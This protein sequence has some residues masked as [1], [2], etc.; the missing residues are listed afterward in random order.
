MIS[1]TPLIKTLKENNITLDKLA[2]DIAYPGLRR[3]LN[4]GTYLSLKTVD[5]ICKRLKC[6]IEDV[7]VYREGEMKKIEYTVGYEVDWGL[8]F[9][10]I[11]KKR[12]TKKEITLS[13]ASVMMGKTKSYLNNASLSRR[14][15]RGIVDN[16]ASFLE[17]DIEKFAKEIKK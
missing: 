13:E 1:Y 14:S 11:Q 12:T 6:S 15:S 2:S 5:S 17:C 9:D 16:L 7:V 10:L 3:K 8:V 4:S